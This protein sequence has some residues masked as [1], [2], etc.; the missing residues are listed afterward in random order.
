MR[1]KIVA[2]KDEALQ[3]FGR[4]IF[5]VALGQAT[6]SFGDEVNNEKSELYAH[7]ADFSLWLLG[8]YD[9][10]KG[11][12]E[13]CEPRLLARGADVS[14]RAFTHVNE[15]GDMATRMIMPARKVS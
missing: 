8:E 7:P 14:K 11:A 10:E 5:V 9:D 3:A 13:G 4:P 6:R 15:A 2:I 12:F 1:Q